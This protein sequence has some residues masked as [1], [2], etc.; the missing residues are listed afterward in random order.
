MKKLYGGAFDTGLKKFTGAVTGRVIATGKAYYGKSFD[1]SAFLPNFSDSISQI[2]PGSSDFNKELYDMLTESEKNQILAD[3]AGQAGLMS[4]LSFLPFLLIFQDT[5]EGLHEMIGI[6]HPELLKNAIDR[7]NKK[8]IDDAEYER[9]KEIDDEIKKQID[10][11][12]QEEQKELSNFEKKIKDQ[13]TEKIVN[14]GL[15]IQAPIQHIPVIR[16]VSNADVPINILRGRGLNQIIH[17]RNRPVIFGD[18]ELFELRQRR[19]RK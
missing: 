13:E 14:M 2:I 12:K 11:Y 5:R 1:I 16:P 10:I 3:K 8:L 7:Y 17:M 15:N 4:P 19:D 9:Q 18:K 6:R